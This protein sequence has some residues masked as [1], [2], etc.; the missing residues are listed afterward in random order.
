MK[1]N[2]KAPRHWP[3][4]GEF[5]GDRWIPRTNGQRRGS[6]FHLMTSLWSSTIQYYGGSVP[7]TLPLCDHDRMNYLP[8]GQSL[9]VC[10]ISW[11][12]LSIKNHIKVCYSSKRHM[13]I[14]VFISRISYIRVTLND[15]S[16]QSILKLI[17]FCLFQHNHIIDNN[18][19]DNEDTGP[20][21]L[22]YTTNCVCKMEIPNCF[23]WL[24]FWFAYVVHKIRFIQ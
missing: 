14:N 15:H 20:C 6:C 19:E 24:L 17:R 2:I 8:Q 3:L 5:T 18:N 7:H 16:Y 10:S 21:L 11:P 23:V 9:I 12:M 22:W 13:I 1:E 4:C